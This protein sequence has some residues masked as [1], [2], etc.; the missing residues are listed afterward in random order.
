MAFGEHKLGFT[1]FGLALVMLSV[2][3]IVLGW[4]G[5][6]GIVLWVLLAVY[7]FI[8]HVCLTGHFLLIATIHDRVARLLGLLGNERLD[9]C[10]LDD[11]Q[12][13][14]KGIDQTVEDLKTSS[15]DNIRFQ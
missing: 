11:R 7:G 3:G 8:G 15:D 5:T 10:E 9:N 14:A 1:L 6:W 4:F 12:Q 13:V 2:T